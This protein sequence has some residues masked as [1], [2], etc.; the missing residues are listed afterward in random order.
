MGFEFRLWDF[1]VFDG[2][3]IVWVFF[4]G[5]VRVFLMLGFF[6]SFGRRV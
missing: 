2:F 6:G 1:R 4:R 5:L 3:L